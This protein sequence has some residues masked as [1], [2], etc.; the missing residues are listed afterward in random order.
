MGLM[1]L[2][3]FSMPKAHFKSGT[4]ERMS[5]LLK[6]VKKASELKR[7]QCILLGASG[8]SSPAIVPLVGLNEVN[9]RRI[10]KRYREKGEQEIVGERRGNRGK[11]HLTLEEEQAFLK[12][13]MEEA[14]SGGILIVSQIHKA[15]EKKIGKALHHSVTYRLLERHGW[16]KIAPRPYHPKRDQAQQE[17]FQDSFPPHHRSSSSESKASGKAFAIDVSR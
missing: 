2:T 15:Y 12:P 9:V 6:E 16:R 17:S 11:A 4:K 5:I 13:F 8:I 10:W 3:P 7:V 1:H 14:Q